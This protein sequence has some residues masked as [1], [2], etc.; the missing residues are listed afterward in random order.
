[1]NKPVVNPWP[2]GSDRSRNCMMSRHLPL[3][4]GRGLLYLVSMWPS[5]RWVRIVHGNGTIFVVSGMKRHLVHRAT[6]AAMTLVGAFLASCADDTPTKP[7]TEPPATDSLHW[8]STAVIY[9]D[10]A[11]KKDHSL[12]FVLSPLCP[13]CRKLKNETLADTSIIRTLNASFNVAQIDPN[14]DSLVTYKD[15]MVTCRQMS[16]SI[17][18]VSGY[19]E[20]IA[21][22]RE[23]DE[24]GRIEGY[25]SPG[26]FLRAVDSVMASWQ[27][28]MRRI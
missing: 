2:A 21:L 3:T 24:L 4:A 19:P 5:L 27:H 23:G 22:S 18:H 8:V 25:L 15:S 12:L 6:L 1:M 14:S 11:G 7:S 16:R 28:W 17:Y 10:A 20:T 13:W 9:G 26:E